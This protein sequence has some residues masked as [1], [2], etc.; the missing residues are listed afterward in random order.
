[1]EEC[2]GVSLREKISDIFEKNNEFSEKQ[3]AALFKDILSVVNFIHEH[4]ICHRC[5]NAENLKFLINDEGSSLKLTH[6]RNCVFFS[7][8]NH[9]FSDKIKTEFI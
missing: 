4:N 6:F 1:M 5:I 7:Q 9:T 2:T 8:Q 3:A